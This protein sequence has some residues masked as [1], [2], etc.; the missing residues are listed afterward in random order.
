MENLQKLAVICGPT[1]SGKSAVAVALAKAVGGEIISADSMQIY[2]GMNIGTA[3]ITPHEA[4]GIPHHLIDIAEPNE[5]FSVAKYQRMAQQCMDEIAARGK[6]PILCGGTGLYIES[7]LYGHDQANVPPAPNYRAD[8]EAYAAQN[9][10]QALHDL[11]R[12]K[13]PQAAADIHP[14]NVKRVIRALEILKARGSLPAEAIRVPRY[15]AAMVGLD[16]PR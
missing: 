2:R 11:L 13:Q 1:A 6:L 9:G 10:V 16:L 4:E 7:V 8:L 5:L 15:H 14:N 12:A 3:K